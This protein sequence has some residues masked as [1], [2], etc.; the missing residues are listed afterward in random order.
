MSK[1]SKVV[2][3]K[4]NAPSSLVSTLTQ[5]IPSPP[6]GYIKKTGCDCGK[7]RL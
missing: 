7:K 1:K 2:S 3:N 6:A 5:S 4:K